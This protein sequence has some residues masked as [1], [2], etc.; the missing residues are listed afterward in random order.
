MYLQKQKNKN[1]IITQIFFTTGSRIFDNDEL[2]IRLAYYKSF[3]YLA[4]FVFL[5]QLHK[6]TITKMTRVND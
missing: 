5:V 4:N 2:F 6:N 3:F 1:K